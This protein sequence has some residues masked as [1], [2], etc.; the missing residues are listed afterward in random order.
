VGLQSSG[1]LGVTGYCRQT[2]P[3]DVASGPLYPDRYVPCLPAEVY[4]TS[5]ETLFLGKQDAMQRQTLVPLHHH[6]RGKP[7]GGVGM[8]CL[9]VACG[10]GRFATFIKVGTQYMCFKHQINILSISSK[11]FCL[12]KALSKQIHLR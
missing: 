5:T 3:V 12:Q 4:E 7:A 11:G 10:T 8:K 1:N 6:M 2:L 9:E